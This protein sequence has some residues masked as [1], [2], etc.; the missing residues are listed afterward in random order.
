M[1]ETRYARE[2]ATADIHGQRIERIFVKEQGQDEIRF[3]WWKDGGMMMRPLDLPESELLPL[4]RE[5]IMKGVFT[6]QFLKELH[7]TL[8]ET[9]Q[10]AKYAIETVA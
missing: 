7:E 5:A 9:R 4:L 8:Y 10:N 3:S 2:R 6:E 1:R